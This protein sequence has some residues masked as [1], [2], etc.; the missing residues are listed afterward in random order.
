MDHPEVLHECA[1]RVRIVAVNH[2]SVTLHGARS[3]EELLA[4]LP[5]T[6]TQSSYDVFREELI[7]CAMG[8]HEMTSEAVVQTIDGEPRNVLIKIFIDPHT[9]EWAN[10]YV[11]I[12]DL[13]QQKQTEAVIRDALHEKEVLLR[14]IHHRVKNNFQVIVSLLKLQ[15]RHLDEPEL[16]AAFQESV[17][18][19]H[20]M[21]MVHE[22]LYGDG[23]LATVEGGD[24]LRAIVADL[25]RLFGGGARITTRVEADPAPLAVDTAIPC[26]L[27]VNELVSNAFKHAF[28]AGRRGEV[29]VEL[30]RRAGD[31]A[32]TR[33]RLTV[34][35]DGVGI[36]PALSL[37]EVESV[38]LR[39]V[40]TLAENQLGGTVE[41]QRNKG[42]SFSMDFTVPA[43]GDLD[44]SA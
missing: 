18:R 32:E 40:A 37:E 35:D 13:T 12:V 27:I 25:K 5:Q 29:Q 17:N 26:G 38:G 11:S 14:E 31:D 15:A 34:R 19:V 23:D 36:D 2:A 41:F 16:K 7:A 3:Q 1:E 8:K 20:T 39:L 10:T 28:P 22:R 44:D 4:G 42:T 21:A 24:Y 6:F 9:P 30:R 43:G 33:Y